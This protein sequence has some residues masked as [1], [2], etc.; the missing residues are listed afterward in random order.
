MRHRVSLAP[1]LALSILASLMLLVGTTMARGD[2]SP[3]V[4]AETAYDDL[5]AVFPDAV[6]SVQPGGQPKPV[7]EPKAEGFAIANT[8]VETV[9]PRNPADPIVLKTDTGPLTLTAKGVAPDAGDGTV[10]PGGAAVVYPNTDSGSDTVLR[11]EAHGVETVTDL[12]TPQAPTDYSWKVGLTGG[13]VL[14]PKDNGAVDVIDPTPPAGAPDAQPA[15]ALDA[16]QLEPLKE[17]GEVPATAVTSDPAAVA[18]A[19][20]AVRESGA[21]AVPGPEGAEPAADSAHLPTPASAEATTQAAQGLPDVAKLEGPTVDP[22]GPLLAPDPDSP[23]ARTELAQQIANGSHAADLADKQAASADLTQ[24]QQAVEAKDAAAKAEEPAAKPTPV[25]VATIEPPTSVDASG[26]DVPTTLTVEG[27]TVTMHV[28]TS[29]PTISFP[30]AADPY[31]LV[32]DHGWVQHQ[33]TAVRWEPRSHLEW[34]HDYI[35]S[36]N[37]NWMI[38]HYHGYLSD[39]NAWPHRYTLY[40][41]AA[42]WVFVHP[43]DWSGIWRISQVVVQDPPVPVY[44]TAYYYSYE[45]VGHHYE[46]RQGPCDD[47]EE[48]YPAECAYDPD[49]PSVDISA[50]EN[51]NSE[52]VDTDITED[53][54]PGDASASRLRRVTIKVHGGSFT[55]VRTYPKSWVIGTAK[56]GWAFDVLSALRGTFFGTVHGDAESCGWV[57]TRSTSPHATGK[58]QSL[59][60]GVPRHIPIK[61]YAYRVNCLRCNQATSGAR[62]TQP[63]WEYGNPNWTSPGHAS[64]PPSGEARDESFTPVRHITA[65]TI[66]AH[67]HAYGVGWRYTSKDRKWVLVKE[68]G[69]RHSNANGNW[70]FVRR[71][72]VTLPSYGRKP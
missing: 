21:V 26:A 1:L 10:V 3:S 47:D 33:Y 38:H 27:D 32:Y 39:R 48:G 57:K 46:W 24:A 19:D 22:P 16:G 44:Y 65:A 25:V 13:Q 36:G 58:P 66:A 7:I 6:V 62:I 52:N 68:P 50:D 17:T 9:L 69:D 31:V 14:K 15:Q 60:A 56:T 53:P 5:H 43:S 70:V 55:T 34:R 28:D 63:T 4:S 51:G 67:H 12:R 42:G 30:V 11:P 8:Q 72:A 18:Q 71:S 23:L 45:V 54:T 40:W 64:D 59:C 2:D 41:P 35:A 49:E 61:A 20:D 37:G 29:D